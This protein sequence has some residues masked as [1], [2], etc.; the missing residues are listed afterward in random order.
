MLAKDDPSKIDFVV[1]PT[2]FGKE[3]SISF[4]SPKTGANQV[5]QQILINR[6]AAS[7]TFLT[8]QMCVRISAVWFFKELLQISA[9]GYTVSFQ[10]GVNR[11][12]C[13]RLR[14]ILRY[15]VFW[16]PIS[17]SRDRVWCESL[18]QHDHIQKAFSFCFECSSCWHL[19]PGSTGSGTHLD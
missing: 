7:L 14:C 4:P 13:S 6:L 11:Q 5:G 2:S 19:A 17:S 3:D 10:P 1:F 18:E 15:E 16:E 8:V 12:T 9:C